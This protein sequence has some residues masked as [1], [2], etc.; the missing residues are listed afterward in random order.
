M[1][2]K[3]YGH[4]C[5]GLKNNGTTIILD[6][7]LNNNPLAKTKASEVKTNYILVTH[8]HDDHLGDALE[9]AQNN[10]ATIITSVEVAKH[11]KKPE[12]NFHGM[13]LG[14]SYL[15]PFG[16]VKMTEALHG[17]GVPGGRASGF[18]IDFFGQKVYFAGDTGLFGDMQLIGEQQE[19][20]IA[21]LPIGDN[22]TMGIDDAV[23][24]A[25]YLK[26]K[27]VIPM[28]YNTWPIIEAN[29]LEFKEK[30]EKNTD[31]KCI[32]LS[33]GEEIEL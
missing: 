29:P 18:V 14:G 20:E 10:Q 5:L 12:I 8:G 13:N 9:I 3:Y 24:A 32:V 27:T 4:A 23:I 25:Q 22:F 21:F 16:R 15:F 26:A 28:H 19:L 1:L 11:C 6:P 30:I 31:S 33:I 2:I 17:A 7:F